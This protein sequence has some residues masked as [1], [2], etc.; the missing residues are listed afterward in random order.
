MSTEH[1]LA[2]F[3]FDGTLIDRDSMLE[4]VRHCRGSTRFFLGMAWLSPVLVAHRLRL[5]AAER[6][7]VIFLRHFLG[8]MERAALAEAAASFADRLDGFLRPGALERVVWHRSQGHDVWVVSASLD[9]WLEPWMERQGLRVLC[10]RGHF[11]GD[12]FTGAL[13]GPN[14][15]GA[16]KALQIQQT[17]DLER[18]ERI[19]AY[20][21]SSGDTEMLALAHEAR[22]KPFRDEA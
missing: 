8:G 22:F 6:A 14:C 9:L 18:Y 20:G 19:Y 12:R 21:D 17:L 5:L 11:D 4:F 2:L 3:D 16:Q 13:S 15:N 7:K 10:T 1:H